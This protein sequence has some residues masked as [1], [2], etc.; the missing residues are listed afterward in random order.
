MIRVISNP[1]WGASILEDTETGD[2][3]FQCLCGGI[4]MYWQRVA[5]LPDEADEVRSGTFDADRMVSEVCKKTA[6]V[7]GRLVDPVDPELLAAD[8]P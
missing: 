2:L 3:S 4:G 1:T 7:A 5:L 6:N 8:D